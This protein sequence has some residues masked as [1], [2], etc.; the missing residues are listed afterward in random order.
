MTSY[1]RHLVQADARNRA[2]RTFVQGAAIDI[3]A[4]ACAVLTTQ[5]GDVHWTRAWW[6]LTGALVLKTVVQTAAAYVARKVVPPA[7]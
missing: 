5:L 7:A 1:S 4:A 3:G 6:A 2:V